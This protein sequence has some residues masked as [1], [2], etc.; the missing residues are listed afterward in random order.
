MVLSTN[1]FSRIFAN[2]NND[3]NWT[4]YGSIT[5]IAVRRNI[6]RQISFPKLIVI[7]T[8]QNIDI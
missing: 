7:S 4:F 8:I 1:S 2:S 5:K 6:M 3:T